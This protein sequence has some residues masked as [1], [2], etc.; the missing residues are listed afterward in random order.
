MQKKYLYSIS[1]AVLITSLLGSGVTALASSHR[2]AP[3]ISGDPKV[4]ATD[5]YAFVSPDSPNTVTLIADYIPFEEPAGGPNFY[6]FDDN[7]LYKI[8]IDNNGDAVPD[9]TYEFQFKTQILNPNTFLYNTGPI[10][11][12][13]D[14]NYNY[15]Q[16]YTLTKVVNGVSTVLG[17]NLPVAPSNIGPKSTP[18][19]AALQAQSLR[20]VD[21][22]TKVFVGQSDDPFYAEL[23][24]LFD[25]LTI[26]NL[27]G[28][29]GG[30]VDGLKGYNVH[31]LALQIPITDITLNKNHPTTVTDPGAVIGVWTTAYRHSTTV[32]GTTPA[33]DSATGNWVQVSRLGA[34]LVN[35]VVVPLGAKDLWNRSNPLDDAQFANGV[36]NPELGTLLKAI[37]NV[38]V[39]PQGPFGSSTQRDDLEAIFLTGIPGLTKP[40]NGVPAEELRLNVAVPPTANPNRMGVLAGDNQGYPNGRR[41][42]DDVVD[43]SIQAVAGAAYPLFHPTFTPDPLA[44][45]LGDGVD[46]NDLPFRTAFPYLALPNQ[47]FT[48]V[49]HGT[50][51]PTTGTGGTSGNGT[52]TTTGIGSG[53]TGMGSTTNMDS[54]NDHMNGDDSNN[55]SGNGKGHKGHSKD[56]TYDNH[57]RG[58][59]MSVTTPSLDDTGGASVTSSLT[60]G[61]PLDHVDFNGRNF[62]NE[63]DVVLSLN[64]TKIQTSHAD[65]VGNFS[66]GSVVLPSTIGTYT[67]RFDGKDSQ[68]VVTTS[69]T[70]SN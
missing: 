62:G 40:A 67:Y 24:G 11:S 69:V 66:T 47:G 30:G 23:G 68:D 26:R 34:P 13:T 6:S 41:L 4:D 33:G 21:T 45:K 59:N 64:G 60:T 43:I 27:P 50:I 3:L 42:A 1:A 10:T 15:R 54:S 46:A 51:V 16:T 57:T 28:N 70:V 7:A 31:S 29:A 25:L 22:S 9:I 58:G 2:E 37:Y 53:D 49:P 48:S 5:L 17:T 65:G 36:A 35:E 19:Y 14:P 38:Q 56:T 32:L 55:Q 8:N 18:N 44:T 61:H 20:T 12:L 63:E 52:G 39:P